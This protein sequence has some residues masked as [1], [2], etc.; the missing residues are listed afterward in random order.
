[1]TELPIFPASAD[2]P[3]TAIEAGF[4]IRFI[5]V[6]ISSWVNRDGSSAASASTSIRTSTA[7]A[8][9]AVASTGFRSTSDSW[10]SP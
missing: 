4:M 1:M 7:V 2:A 5:A 8:P 3:I 6:R 10:G 9:D